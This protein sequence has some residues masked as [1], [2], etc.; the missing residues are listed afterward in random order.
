MYPIN[1]TRIGNKRMPRRNPIKAFVLI[2][3]FRPDGVI[4][5]DK[6]STRCDHC[7][8]EIVVGETIAVEEIEWDGSHQ[9]K[10]PIDD[11]VRRWCLRCI[12]YDDATESNGSP[13]FVEAARSRFNRVITALTTECKASPAVID[14]AFLSPHPTIPSNAAPLRPIGANELAELHLPSDDCRTLAADLDHPFE[15][16]LGY[17]FSRILKCAPAHRP[18]SLAELSLVEGDA[19]WLKALFQQA[20]ASKLHQ[21]VLGPSRFKGYSCGAQLGAVLLLLESELARRHAS[22]GMLWSAIH[23]QVS[24]GDDANRFLFDQRQPNS[25][26]KAWLEA[27]AKELGL[28]C[29]FGEDSS[30]EWYQSV[31]LQCGFSKRSFERRLPEWLSGQ[32]TPVSVAR[33]LGSDARYSSPNFKAMWTALQEYRHGVLDRPGLKAI[34]ESSP[35]V[36]PEWHESLVQLSRPDGHPPTPKDRQFH[37]PVSGDKIFVPEGDDATTLDR[38]FLS[39]PRL[40]WSDGVLH[41]VSNFES[42]NGLDLGDDADIVIDGQVRSRLIVQADG[43]FD[44]TPNE[45]ELPKYSPSVV[46]ELRSLSA[47]T[48]ATQTLMLWNNEDDADG[49]VV[50]TGRRMDPWSREFSQRET[51]L[52]YSADLRIE[53]PHPCITVLGNGAKHVV[54]LYPKE[55]VNTRLLLGNDLIWEPDVRTYPEWRDRII[56]DIELSPREAPT[57]FR[58]CVS[59][60]SEVTATA[61][62]FQ[63]SLLDLRR[64]SDKRSKSEWRPLDCDLRIAENIA[65]T[66]LLRM[67]DEK[68]ELRQHVPFRLPGHLWRR[69]DRWET[70]PAHTTCE[71]HELRQAHFRLSPPEPEHNGD[72]WQLFEGRRW[73]DSVRN[74]QQRITAVEG[75]GAPLVLRASTYNCCQPEQTLLQGLSDQGEICEVDFG[76]EM[77]VRIYLHRPIMPDE[78]HAIVVLDKLGNITSIGGAELADAWQSDSTATVWNVSSSCFARDRGVLALAIAYNGERLGSWWRNDWTIVLRRPENVASTDSGAWAS[79]VADALRWTHVPLLNRVIVPHVSR[80]ARAYAVPVLSTWLIPHSS[81]QLAH[82]PIGEGWFCVLREIFSDWFPTLSEAQELDDALELTLSGENELPLK[83]TVL[84]LANINSMLAARFVRARLQTGCF[85]AAKFNETRALIEAIKLHVLGRD[86][87][88]SLVL[89]VAQDVA[90][91]DKPPEG[92]LDFVRDSLLAKSLQLFDRSN[93]ADLTELD[94]SNIEVAMRLGAFRSLVLAKCLDQVI[95]ELL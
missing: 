35:W 76:P 21:F 66:V 88:D 4:Q 3:G 37:E 82:D 69:G 90:S 64:D 89:R 25:R 11:S 84:A 5:Q 86:S 79:G 2:H 10:F 45:V 92:T 47:G 44:A 61:I 62:R 30:Q 14:P 67:G 48:I 46:A 6:S 33:L 40:R 20:T 83:T 81:R 58:I 31:F 12:D 15:N 24:W 60:P 27:A 51:L 77:A 68:T 93:K 91:T 54:R 59:H 94:R 57:K 19:D 71:L 56:A 43:S 32:N 65:F 74:R 13:Y 16:L 53:P 49:Y 28:R 63:R 42:I 50:R 22:E 78:S 41:F 72:R 70:V 38:P 8:D 39:E 85:K 55:M 17:A 26:H 18:W 34:L 7:C 80:F 29:A 23:Q 95:K 87:A 9:L 52:I 75:W 73:I 36:L 1:V